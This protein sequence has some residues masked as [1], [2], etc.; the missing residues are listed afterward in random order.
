MKAIRTCALALN[1]IMAFTAFAVDP[2]GTLPLLTITTENKTP[3]TSKEVYLDATYT[4]DPKGDE[5]MEALSGDMEI[6]GRGNYT[7]WGGMEKKPYRIKLSQKE[8]FMGMNKSKHFALMAH[9]DDNLGFLREPLGFKLSELSGLAWTPDMKPVE[10]IINDDYIGLYF[11]VETIRVD[12]DRVNVFDQEDEDPSTDV[13][14]G[15]L[16]ELDNYDEDLSE[17]IRLTD[18]EGQILRI[19]HKSPELCTPEQEN[20]L[21]EQITEMDRT[22]YIDDPN[23]TEWENLIDKAS[24]AKYFILQELMLGEESFHGSCYFHRDRGADKK[25]VWGPVWDFGYTFNGN[26]DD[27]HIYTSPDWG[28]TWIHRLIRFN[29]FNDAAKARFIE[30]IDNNELDDALSYLDSFAALIAEAAKAD[31]KRWPSYGNPDVLSK[32][33]TIKKMLKKRVRFLA[34]F[35]GV[36]VD[37]EVPSGIYLRGDLN[38]WNAETAYEFETIGTNTYELKNVRLYDRFKIADAGWNKHNWG[39]LKGDGETEIYPDIT[40]EL[41][42]TV[43]YNDIRVKTDQTYASVLFKIIDETTANITLYTSTSVDVIHTDD[44]STI[45]VDGNRVV[46]IDGIE[47]TVYDLAGR[48]VAHGA[49]EISL[50]EGI[51]IVTAGN[52]APIKVAIR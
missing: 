16:V 6:R 49:A 12:K 4:L 39:G 35:Y 1:L 8:K 52:S 20:F 19:T 30:F 43:N 14:G 13:T 38:D 24:I 41:T 37:I 28:Q 29:S 46:S 22:I 48:Q 44:E 21:I 7:W 31:A 2:S 40:L 47:L 17:Q 3:I 18:G 45:V 33:E 50:A 26:I 27:D 5:S 51:Y 36:E 15:W 34:D 25:W 42:N 11:V 23:S 32:C 9:A 10:L